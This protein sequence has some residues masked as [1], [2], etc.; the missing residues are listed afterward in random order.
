[1]KKSVPN[2]LAVFG[3][4]SFILSLT[5]ASLVDNGL[6]ISVFAILLS[7]VVNFAIHIGV[8]IAFRKDENNESTN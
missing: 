4:L 6:I 5:M 3:V 2:W 8:S 1:M 7:V